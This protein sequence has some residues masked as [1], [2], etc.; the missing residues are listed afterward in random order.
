[1]FLN[2]QHQVA[3]E[4]DWSERIVRR[5][6]RRHHFKD[7]GT[8]IEHL[9]DNVEELEMEEAVDPTSPTPPK[10]E[11]PKLSVVIPPRKCSIVEKMPVNPR[12]A[13]TFRQE[14]ELLHRKSICL[15]CEKERRRCVLL[16]CAH[17][18]VCNKCSTEVDRC[19]VKSCNEFILQK[20][21]TIF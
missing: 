19:P 11:K 2:T 7:A 18:A 9:E 20:I 10:R 21:P 8:L 3:C 6:L 12:K 1:M 5:V 16:P 4:F 14:T 17:L 13:L 15:V